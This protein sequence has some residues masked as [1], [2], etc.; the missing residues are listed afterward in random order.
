MTSKHGN[1]LC[2]IPV[3]KQHIVPEQYIVHMVSVLH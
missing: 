3:S 2:D 1:V